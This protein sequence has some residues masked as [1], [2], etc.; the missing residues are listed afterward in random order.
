MGTVRMQKCATSQ[1]C[2]GKAAIYAALKVIRLGFVLF[3][4]IAGSA[5]LVEHRSNICL[6]D[7]F[8]QLLFALFNLFL[9]SR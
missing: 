3:A 6:L 9:V 1:A 5:V 4:T 8:N 2:K 7:G